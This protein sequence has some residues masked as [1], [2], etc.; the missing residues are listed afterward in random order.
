[1]V[2]EASKLLF[3]ERGRKKLRGKEKKGMEDIE[4]ENSR[5]KWGLEI[6]VDRWVMQAV[7]GCH[8]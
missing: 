5:R 1:M 7:T 4:I 6:G 2:I 8:S 3:R